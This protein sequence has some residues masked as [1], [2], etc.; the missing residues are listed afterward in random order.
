[1]DKTITRH[2]QKE[3]YNKALTAEVAYFDEKGSD[4]ILN[5]IVTEAGQGGW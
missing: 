2:L 3:A 5:T 1:L 4:D